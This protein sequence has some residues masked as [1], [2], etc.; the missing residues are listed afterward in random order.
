LA[1]QAGGQR[2]LEHGA[3]PAGVA[4]D[5]APVAAQDPGGRPAQGEGQLR[6]ELG[7]GHAPHPIGPELQHGDS[8]TNAA[9]GNGTGRPP[10]EPASDATTTR[11]AVQL[12]GQRLLYCG[13][14]RAFFRPYFFDSFT[15][16]SRV[17]KPARLSGTRSSGSS[18]TSARAMPSRSAP[19][20]P[21]TPPPRRVASMS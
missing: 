6:G 2:G 4:P 21:D 9:T 8:S 14:L 18:S 5:G 7:V 15:R 17:R 11:V 13:A 20:W 3:R 16:G 12:R 10:Q 19:A 1:G